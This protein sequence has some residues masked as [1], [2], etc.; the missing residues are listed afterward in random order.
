M[1]KTVAIALFSFFS[2]HADLF[3]QKE[4]RVLSPDGH[5]VFNL[6]INTGIPVYSVS[7]N[8]NLLINKSSLN[9]QLEGIGMFRQALIARS[10]AVKE[11]KETY[12]L[13]VGKAGNVKNNYRQVVI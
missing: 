9:I 7:Y 8:K 6:A 5:I 12:K 10:S 4:I 11:I 1:K 2:L 3:A 13:F